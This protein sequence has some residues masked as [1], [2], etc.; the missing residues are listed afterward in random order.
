VN[1]LERAVADSIVE[2]NLK[3][4]L[5]H[6]AVCVTI[7]TLFVLA[8]FANQ[9]GLLGPNTVKVALVSAAVLPPEAA[10]ASSLTAQL[11]NSPMWPPDPGGVP[12]AAR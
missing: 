4:T 5:K 6:L 10:S 2:I 3:N 9:R 1:R 7:C 12:S 11:T 8:A